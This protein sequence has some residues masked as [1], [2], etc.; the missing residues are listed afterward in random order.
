MHLDLGQMIVSSVV[1]GL[2][3]DVIFKF[4]RHLTAWQTLVVAVIGV[5][6]VWVGSQVFK[7]RR[8]R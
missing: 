7:G 4:T 5:G 3:Y 8:R 6:A 2:I 1:H